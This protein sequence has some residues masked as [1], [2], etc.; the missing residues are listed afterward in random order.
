MARRSTKKF[1]F[2]KGVYYFNINKGYNNCIT[3]KRTDKKKALQA[4]SSYLK[5]YSDK[6]EWLGKW[7]G[8]DFVESNFETLRKKEDI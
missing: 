5:L 4:Y 1:E 3:I 2:G 8:K 6:C 7:N